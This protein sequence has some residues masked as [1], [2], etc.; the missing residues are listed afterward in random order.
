M[1]GS[2]IVGVSDIVAASL[3]VALALGKLFICKPIFFETG[4]QT[5]PWG[6]QNQIGSGMR[7]ASKIRLPLRQ[8]PCRQVELSKGLLVRR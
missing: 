2:K 4:V 7:K 3:N 1:Q 5:S 8:N 6:S